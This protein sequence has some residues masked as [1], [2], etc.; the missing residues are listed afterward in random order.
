[1]DDLGDPVDLLGLQLTHRAEDRG[2]GIIHPN[3]QR[4]A[5]LLHRVGGRFHLRGVGDI[6]RNL[7]RRTAGGLHLAPYAIQAVAA[8]REQANPRLAPGEGSHDRPSHAGGG[9]RHHDHGAL[10]HR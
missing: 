1:M 5:G 7:Q 9:A 4:A 3:V 2:H 10:F 6:G 8:A